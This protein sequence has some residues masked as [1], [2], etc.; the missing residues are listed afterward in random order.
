V[1]TIT[2]EGEVFSWGG[3]YCGQL[4][5]GHNYHRNIPQRVEFFNGKQIINIVSGYDHV[6]AITEEE[7][8]FSWGR[9]DYGQLG[10]CHRN[11]C[12]APQQVNFF[13]EHHLKLPRKI[14]KIKSAR[15]ANY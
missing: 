9:N 12:N 14:S 13:N 3:N 8:V 4:G 1:F 11:D 15:S 6:I 10:L 2:G 7:E 5:L